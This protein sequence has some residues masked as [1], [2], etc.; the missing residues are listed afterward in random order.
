ML[1][2]GRGEE[3]RARRS[4]W[5]VPSLVH[6]GS[7]VVVL[8]RLLVGVIYPPPCIAGVFRLL[9][10]QIVLFVVMQS[11]ADRNVLSRS[12]S[13][14]LSACLCFGVRLRSFSSRCCSSSICEWGMTIGKSKGRSPCMCT[15]VPDFA[16]VRIVQ[17]ASGLGDTAE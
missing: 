6:A 17:A 11:L 12:P 1:P 7:L 13:L 9:A 5:R 3:L 15:S 4:S 16:R 10:Q 2:C 14:C 8:L